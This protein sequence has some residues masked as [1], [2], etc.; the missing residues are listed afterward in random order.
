LTKLSILLLLLVLLVISCA[1]PDAPPSIETMTCPA[2]PGS[3]EPHLIVHKNM[4][5]LSW[6]VHHEAS[7]HTL[8]YATFADDTWSAVH[9]IYNSDQLFANWA[10]RPS[11]LPLAD[12]T[13][14]AHWLEKSGGDPYAYD[15]RLAHS[16]DG[17]NWSDSIVPHDDGTQTE[18]G[19]VSM[20]PTGND[21]VLAVWLDGRVY[22]DSDH[23]Q[24]EMSLRAPRW[25]PS[26]LTQA[27]VLDTR[28]CDCCPTSAVATSR[29]FLVAYR[30]RSDNET[31]DISLVR[32]QDGVWSEPWT[33]HNDG[34]IIQGCPVNGPELAARDNQVVATWFTQSPQNMVQ[35]AFSNDAGASFPTLVRVDDGEPAGR[36]DVVLLAN[37]D[38]FVIWLEAPAEGQ[39]AI[40]GR[41]VRRN[42]QIEPSLLIA[43]TDGAR[44]SG[45]PRL[46]KLGDTLFVAWTDA[47]EPSQV[48]MA[49]ITNLH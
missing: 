48:R 4:L 24:A 2:P 8:Q 22:A 9:D 47:S 31:R 18:H 42:G 19:F 45:Y 32:L 29:G 43:D 17:R 36:T 49:T 35:V 28:T 14:M 11:I 10:D 37:G 3:A 41:L 40:R 44:S 5:A 46:E 30:D 12:G 13:W 6:L 26:G 39:A 34:W 27:A 15:V 21:G 38:A 7:G 25:S 23:D 33:L 16:A 1:A 20:L